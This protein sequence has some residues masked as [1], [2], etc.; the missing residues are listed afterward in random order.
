MA[1][2]GRAPGAVPGAVNAGVTS[3][4]AAPDDGSEGRPSPAIMP[5]PRRPAPRPPPPAGTTGAP[6]RD[7]RTRPARR[8]PAQARERSALPPQGAAP[9]GRPAAARSGLPGGDRCGSTGEP[10]GRRGAFPKHA[11]CGA[12][13]KRIVRYTPLRAPPLRAPLLHAPC[14]HPP[15]MPLAQSNRANGTCH[16]GAQARFSPP[17][18]RGK[19]RTAKQATARAV[20]A[21]AGVIG[22]TGELPRA[23]ASPL[24]RELERS[25]RVADRVG[26]PCPAVLRRATLVR[27]AAQARESGRGT[28][29]EVHPITLAAGGLPVAASPR[30]PQC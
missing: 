24:P 23:A 17:L 26:E 9:N 20:R 29:P 15:C 30:F 27:F 8:S 21:T 10:A 1:S 18:A 25:V 6:A 14:V 13:R 12:G 4:G 2:G 22:G 16:A 5:H 11:P 19:K 7:R 28:C 3:G